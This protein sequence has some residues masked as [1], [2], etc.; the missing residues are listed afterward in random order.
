MTYQPKSLNEQRAARGAGGA[1]TA[2]LCF[3]LLGFV[4][5]FRGQSPAE[6]APET[7]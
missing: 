3:A 7:D 6:M 5:G 1:R 4:S 2:L